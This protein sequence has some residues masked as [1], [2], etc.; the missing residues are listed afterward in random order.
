MSSLTKQRKKIEQ[1]KVRTE[2]KKSKRARATGSTPRFPIHLENE[3]DGVLPEP[4]GS[5][6]SEK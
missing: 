5:H 3:S 4:P 6:P 1:R 2:G